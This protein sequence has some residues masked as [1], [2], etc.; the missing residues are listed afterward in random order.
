MY[1]RQTLGDA[2]SSEDKATLAEV[3][4]T[5][6]EMIKAIKVLDKEMDAAHHVSEIFAHAKAY[7]EKVFAQMGVVRSLADKL[8]GLIP[9]DYYP[10]PTY[11]D[12]L[13]KH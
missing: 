1:K 5:N 2:D 12:L 11:Q 6:N 8:E 7:R 3:V 13:F 10:F 4:K 9:A